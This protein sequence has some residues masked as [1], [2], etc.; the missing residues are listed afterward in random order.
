MKK[1]MRTIVEKGYDE[2]DYECKFRKSSQPNKMEEDFLKTLIEA[3]LEGKS[4]DEEYHF[5]VL[6]K[7]Q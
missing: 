5:W 6:A 2:G 3:T 4:G 7:K 1:D